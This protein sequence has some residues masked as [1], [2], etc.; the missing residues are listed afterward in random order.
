MRITFTTRKG[1]LA[2]QGVRPT[3]SGNLDRFMWES[4]LSIR[5]LSTFFLLLK[6]S[7]HEILLVTSSFLLCSPERPADKDC[8]RGYNATYCHC[9]AP[10]HS[11]PYSPRHHH[12]GTRW[13][14][15]VR[16][17]IPPGPGCDRLGDAN[18]AF[19]VFIC[20][21]FSLQI[22]IVM[23]PIYLALPRNKLL[24]ISECSA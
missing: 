8:V 21:S 2:D 10:R 22:I 17:C 9:N 12:T 11:R 14:Y 6:Y 5:W 7:W 16:F 1:F 15:T 19:T 18:I 24:W 13:G 20:T 23:T 4:Y 3:T